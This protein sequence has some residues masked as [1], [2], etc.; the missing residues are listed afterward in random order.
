[1]QDNIKMCFLE[2]VW[3]GVDWSIVAQDSD[4]VGAS[5]QRAMNFRDTQMRTIPWPDEDL[6]ASQEKFSFIVF[7]SKFVCSVALDFINSCI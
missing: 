5:V 4:K 6:L 7:V 3:E 2:I 1:M